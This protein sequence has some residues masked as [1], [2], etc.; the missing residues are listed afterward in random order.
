[1]Q[2]VKKI[3]ILGGGSAGWMTAAA[4]STVLRNQYSDIHLIESEAVGTVSVGEATIPQIALFNRILGLDENEFVRET[5]ATFKLGIE[6]ANW[7]QK[8]HSYMHP[9]GSFGT[10]MDAIQFHHFW[11]KGTLCP[12]SRLTAAAKAL[13][14]PR[15]T[16][17][18]SRWLWPALGRD[19]AL[20]CS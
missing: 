12:M 18:G 17:V 4:L 19:P 10:D 2:P 6:F 16:K 14:L 5:Q 9:F 13:R 15:S 11:L 20:L 7:K 3:V 8:G 1:M